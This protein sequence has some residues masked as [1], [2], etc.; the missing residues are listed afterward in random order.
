MIDTSAIRERFCGVGGSLS[1]RGRRLFAAAEAQT[2]GYGGIGAA[3]RA[4]GVARGTIGRG[5]KDL[6]NPDIPPGTLRRPG[7]GRRAL[8]NTGPTPD[9]DLRQLLEPAT[10]GDPIRPLLWVSKSRAKLAAA[11]CAMGH[12]ISASSIP[13]LLNYRRQENRK[14]SEGSHN[15][16]RDAQFEHLN[17]AAIATQA[18]GQPAIS[19]DTK[20][21][22]I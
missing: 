6:T 19:I 7:S 4:T 8:T 21:P 16:D 11:L 1:R 9:A 17:A 22:E 2:A 3:A 20:K 5:L 13:K 10:M 14:T 15:P 18:A 12:R